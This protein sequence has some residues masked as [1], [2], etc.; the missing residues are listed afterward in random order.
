MYGILGLSLFIPA[1]HGILLHGWVAQNKR[2]SLTYFIGLGLLNG[3]GTAIY[4]VRILERWYPRKF[5]IYGAS[6]HIMHV[7]V[8]CGAVSHTIGLVKAF[9]Y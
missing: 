7:L 5:D 3:L 9:D 2:M 6:H 4:A 8:I 1:V